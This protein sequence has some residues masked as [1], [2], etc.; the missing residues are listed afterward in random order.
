M[1][2]MFTSSKVA[3]CINFVMYTRPTFIKGLQ[4]SFLAPGISGEGIISKKYMDKSCWSRSFHIYVLNSET[5][6]KET[7]VDT[8]LPFSEP[9][10][11]EILHMQWQSNCHQNDWNQSS[12]VGEII[13]WT[14]CCSCNDIRMGGQSIKTGVID[15]GVDK[16]SECKLGSSKKPLWNQLQM[17]DTCLQA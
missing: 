17:A 7:N 5:Y 13:N 14:I 11:H 3:L 12:V 9:T 16:W 15:T 2:L 1:A 8:Y 6:K 10:K 4:S